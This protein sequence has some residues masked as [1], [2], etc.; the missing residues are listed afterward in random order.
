MQSKPQPEDDGLTMQRLAPGQFDVVLG[1]HPARRTAA[2]GKGNWP[3]SSILI[4]LALLIAIIFL[5]AQMFR[6]P[7]P[8]A[9]VI[10]APPIA[11]VVSEP[12]PVQPVAQVRNVEQVVYIAPKADVSQPATARPLDTCLKDGNVIDR[13]VINCRFGDAQASDAPAARPQGMVS[14]R[15]LANYKTV[16]AKPKTEPARRYEVAGVFIR[17]ID[18]RNRY[19]ARYRIYNNHVEVSSVCMNFLAD[20]VEHREC[21]RAAAPYFKDMCSDWSKRLAKDKSDKNKLAQEQYCE[22]ARTY[23]P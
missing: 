23:Q 13:D 2:S 19:E 17:E 18:G 9:T 5:I 11:E 3:F 7:K 22:A 8:A 12:E 4:C 15:Y 20:S 1:S 6:T 21:R 16:A 10:P 14:D